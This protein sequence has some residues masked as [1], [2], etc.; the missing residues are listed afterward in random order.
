MSEPTTL[1]SRRLNPVVR[2]G[3]V[4]G[5]VVTLWVVAWATG[6]LEHLDVDGIRELVRSAGAWGIVV[7]VIAFCV[8]N[9]L[10][11]PGMVFIVV[12]VVAF[13]DV[14]G[15]VLSW[16]SALL[17]VSTTFLVFRA[18]GGRALGELR[19]PWARRIL[20]GLERRPVLTV[21]VLRIFMQASPVLNASLAL[22]PIR[23]DRY[24]LGSAVGL[25]VPVVAAVLLTGW[26][27]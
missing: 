7:F 17:S 16:F 23:F 6:L 24:L 13:G 26:F 1:P 3:I 2:V 12:G 22:A 21:A 14:T 25:V 9:L 8:A 19:H 4:A 18:L 10:Q 15:G 27:L 11:V 5:V 20:L